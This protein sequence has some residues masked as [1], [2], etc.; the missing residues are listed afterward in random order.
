M[1]LSFDRRRAKLRVVGQPPWSSEAGSNKSAVPCRFLCRIFRHLPRPANS[2]KK[3]YN[4]LCHPL[5][6]L[7]KA[8]KIYLALYSFIKKHIYCKIQS[9][10]IYAIYGVSGSIDTGWSPSF[11]LRIDE[12]R[13]P[14]LTEAKHAINQLNDRGE[15][16]K[17]EMNILILL[18]HLIAHLKPSR[19]VLSLQVRVSPIS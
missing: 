5:F 3:K 13:H 17:Y 8:D 11:H 14:R 15:I 16:C 9:L 10:Y 1:K 2:W 6:T 4:K 19:K 7:G 18:I 12:E